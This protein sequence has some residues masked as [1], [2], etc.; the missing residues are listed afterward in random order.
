MN[1]KKSRIVIY[2]KTQQ[3][4]LF[5]PIESLFFGIVRILTAVPGEIGKYLPRQKPVLG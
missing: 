2:I 4:L 1:L 5:S 3:Y